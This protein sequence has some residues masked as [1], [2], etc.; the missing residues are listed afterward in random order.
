MHAFLTYVFAQ[1]HEC[2]KICLL[3]YTADSDSSEDE[4]ELTTEEAAAV[5][6]SW[7]VDMDRH[8]QRKIIILM[9]HLL[10]NTVGMH[11]ADA[12]KQV[13]ARFCISDR[14]GQKM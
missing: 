11:K 8:Q 10:I 3:Q 6:D 14:S 7:V 13:A 9:T 2:H 5:L 4:F 12:Y 1:K